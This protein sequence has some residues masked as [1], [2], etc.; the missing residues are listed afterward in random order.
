MPPST[1]WPWR[2]SQRSP[3]TKD[4]RTKAEFDAALAKFGTSVDERIEALGGPKAPKPKL[5]AE[6]ELADDR[7]QGRGAS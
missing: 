6:Y 3:H 4:P 1:A 7:D 5:T 2:G